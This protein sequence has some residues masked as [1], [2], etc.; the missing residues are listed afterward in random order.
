MLIRPILYTFSYVETLLMNSKGLLNFACCC[1]VSSGNGAARTNFTLCLFC[2]IYRLHLPYWLVW[3]L[4][5]RRFQKCLW[6][7][8]PTSRRWFFVINCLA[9]GDFVDGNYHKGVWWVWFSLYLC[10][11]RRRLR[12]WWVFVDWWWRILFTEERY[13]KPFRAALFVWFCFLVC[14]T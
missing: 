11:F 10:Y 14:F 12:F 2:L 4:F 3:C 8:R 13:F 5:S 9:S 1:P 6:F 7:Y